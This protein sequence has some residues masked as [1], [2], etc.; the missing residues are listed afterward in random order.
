MCLGNCSSSAALVLPRH[1][2]LTAGLVTRPVAHANWHS[3]D[4]QNCTNEHTESYRLVAN[5]TTSEMVFKFIKLHY[6]G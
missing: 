5:P 2:D 4:T 3:P 6:V 1:D